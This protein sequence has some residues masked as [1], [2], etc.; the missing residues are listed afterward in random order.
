MGVLILKPNNSIKPFIDIPE[1]ST[2]HKAF[3][4][5]LLKSFVS[6]KLKTNP[7]RRKTLASRSD[8]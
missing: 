4:K 8:D 1:I 2:T 3:F 5:K 7:R 6:E